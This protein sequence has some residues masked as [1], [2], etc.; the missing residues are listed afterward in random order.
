MSDYKTE[1]IV[2][3]NIL[4]EGHEQGLDVSCYVDNRGDVILYLDN[5]TLRT[6]YSGAIE[7]SQCL[8]SAAS[9]LANLEWNKDVG[10]PE[11]DEQVVTHV[12]SDIPK[13]RKP[14]RPARH[15]ASGA[16][17]VDNWNPNDPSNW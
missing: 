6:N 5:L 16:Q 14:G 8:S 3:T 12:L 17:R 9:T 4:C 1:H 7:L 15:P 2:D 10:D 13:S 11:G